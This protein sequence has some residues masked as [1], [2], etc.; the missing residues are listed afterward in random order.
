MAGVEAHRQEQRKRLKKIDIGYRGELA[1]AQAKF[2]KVCDEL[3]AKYNLNAQT[4]MDYHGFPIAFHEEIA[5]AKAEYA[6]AVMAAQQ[7]KR[8]GAAAL[9]RK[10]MIV[11]AG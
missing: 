1:A 10:R 6:A 11:R 7:N 8:S 9:P 4:L 2:N 5:P 3:M